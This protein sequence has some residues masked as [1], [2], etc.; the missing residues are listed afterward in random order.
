LVT[1]LAEIGEHFLDVHV[2]SVEQRRTSLGTFEP[3]AAL[4]ARS[5][6]RFSQ[7]SFLVSHKRLAELES[8][9]VQHLVP[10]VEERRAV[11]VAVWQI[12]GSSEEAVKFLSGSFVIVASGYEFVVGLIVLILRPTLDASRH[13]VVEQLGFSS[14]L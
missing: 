1:L 10:D 5:L 7:Q 13:A 4:H 3:K 12:L 9:V 6:L 8:G 14:A 2:P 11:G